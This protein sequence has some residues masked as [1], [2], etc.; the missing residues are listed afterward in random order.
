MENNETTL[1]KQR[2]VSRIEKAG[3]LLVAYSGGADSTFLLAVAH[4]TLGQGVVAATAVSDIFPLRE[5]QDA[6]IFTREQGI[7]HVF[8]RFEETALP[9]FVSNRPDRCYH[10]KKFLFQKM[11][12]IARDRGI[13]HVVHGANADDLEDY[14]P[15]LKA[16]Q[17]MGILAPLLEVGLNK[18]DIR[19]L[20]KRMGLSQWDKPPMACLA[21]RIPYGSPITAEKLQMI[22]KAEAFLFEM[23]VRQCRVRHHGSVARIELDAEGQKIIM[24]P[25]VRNA[26]VGKFREIG[27]LHVALDLEGYVSG[28]MNREIEDNKTT[29]K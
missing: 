12:Q 21:T 5:E 24:D 6:R 15:G 1:K 26:I 17:E 4:E 20:S 27:F 14:R 10:C 16:A 18:E 19:L 7:E 22:E 9:A 11:L 3:T 23:N 13:H 8:F 2:L 28:S 29:K 25:D